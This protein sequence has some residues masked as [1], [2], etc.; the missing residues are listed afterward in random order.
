M[1]KM[2]QEVNQQGT[3][4]ILT[5]HYLE[6]AESLCRNIAIINHGQIV[7]N[8]DM[9]SLLARLHVDHFV[10]DLAQ[11]IVAAPVIEGYQIERVADKVLNVAVP[12]EHGLN[13]LFSQLTA[14]NIEVISLKNKTNRLEQLFMDLVESSPKPT[15]AV[16]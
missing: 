1:W 8:S 4:I 13:K 3:T 14:H 5:T 16:R 9:A 10:L 15:G 6:E 11:P 2:M 7:E 12:K